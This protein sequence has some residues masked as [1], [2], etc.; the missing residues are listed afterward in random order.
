MSFGDLEKIKNEVIQASLFEE[1]ADI[2]NLQALE[3]YEF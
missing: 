1:F 2:K 3:P